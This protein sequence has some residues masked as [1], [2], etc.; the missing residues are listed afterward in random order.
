MHLSIVVNQLIFVPDS[1][2][3]QNFKQVYAYPPVF[4]TDYTYDRF[5]IWRDEMEEGEGTV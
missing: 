1:V 5:E 2:F 4:G 3:Q